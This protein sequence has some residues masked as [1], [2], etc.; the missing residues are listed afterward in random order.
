MNDSGKAV[1]ELGKQ[2]NIPPTVTQN[3]LCMNII[4]PMQQMC[5]VSDDVDLPLGTI[6]MR[7]RGSG[8]G[9]K[10]VQDVVQKLCNAKFVRLRVGIGRP[11]SSKVDIADYVLSNFKEKE[12]L[13]L[14]QALN[15]A[16]ACLECWIVNGIDTAMNRFNNKNVCKEG[17]II[18]PSPSSQICKLFSQ[19]TTQLQSVNKR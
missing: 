12:L 4:T 10:G 19:T 18:K 16:Q 13:V 9:Q 1:K 11:H 7:N 8:G 14:E 3:T 2:L 15:R 5:V 6:R 17:K